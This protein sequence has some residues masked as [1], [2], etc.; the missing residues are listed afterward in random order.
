MLLHL[1]THWLDARWGCTWKAKWSCSGLFIGSI[2]IG[3][4]T[5]S[6]CFRLLLS[7]SDD[8]KNPIRNEPKMLEGRSVKKAPPYLLP[9][10]VKHGAQGM[11]GQALPKISAK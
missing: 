3:A 8:T 5:D 6:T 7:T 11:L 9:L 2:A 4:S 10:L 1:K